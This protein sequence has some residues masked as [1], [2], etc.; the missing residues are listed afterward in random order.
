MK[1][2]IKRLG[3]AEGDPLVRAYLATALWSAG[4]DDD[5]KLL[6]QEFDLSDFALE[7]VED[8]RK[9]VRRFLRDASDLLEPVAADDDQIMHD[10]S[11]T[12]N[13]HGAGFWDRPELYGGDDNA[14]AL[15]AIAKRFGETTVYVGDDGKLYFD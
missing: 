7:A 15:T 11:L 2:N 3:S 6:D 4:E 10:F 13:G 5:G 1:R 14:N 12:R 9:D 8:A